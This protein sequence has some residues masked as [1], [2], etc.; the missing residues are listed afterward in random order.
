MT[1]R[2]LQPLVCSQAYGDKK[3]NILV[4]S[5][6]PLPNYRADCDPKYGQRKS[7]VSLCGLLPISSVPFYKKGEGGCPS[8]SGTK[9]YT[10]SFV[11]ATF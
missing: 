4:V 5:K 7:D 1:L 10:R 3:K 8:L 11:G 2:S 9:A 6:V